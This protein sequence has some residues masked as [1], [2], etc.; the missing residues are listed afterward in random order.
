MSATVLI[1]DPEIIAIFISPMPVFNHAAEK[2]VTLEREWNVSISG[3]AVLPDS[4]RDT[5]PFVVVLPVISDTR[6][7]SCSCEYPQDKRANLIRAGWV[8]RSVGFEVRSARVR[9][10]SACHLTP[11]LSRAAER[12]RQSHNPN[13]TLPR[14]RS[15]LGLNELLGVP[16]DRVTKVQA[17]L[18]VVLEGAPLL[19]IDS[20]WLE[21]ADTLDLNIDPAM[22]G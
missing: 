16:S 18:I 22:L 11:E 7:A 21:R 6:C 19:G 4:Q 10:I 3:F 15:G 1:S 9:V 20:L 13:G 8:D 14:P 5:V 12:P 17:L 2:P